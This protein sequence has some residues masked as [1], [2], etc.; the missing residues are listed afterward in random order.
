[1]EWMPIK[2]LAFSMFCASLAPGVQLMAGE[3]DHWESPVQAGDTCRY[4][5]PGGPVDGGWMLRGNADTAWNAGP[6]GVG[7]GDGDD[8]TES[9]TCLSVYCRYRFGLTDPSVITK[10]ILDVDFDDGFVAYLNGVELARNNLGQAGSATSWDQPADGWH[11]ADLYQGLQPMRFVPEPEILDLLVPGENIL[12]IEV[13]NESLSSSDLSSNVFLHAGI[14]TQESYFPAPP[15]WFSPPFTFRETG[16]PL[17]VIDTRGM[18]ILNEPRIT[19]HM[20]LVFHPDGTPGT[21]GG[22]FNGYDGQISI[23]LRGESTLWIYPKKSYSIELQEPDGSNNNVSLLGLPEENDF[24]LYGPYGDKSLIRN[25]LTYTLYEQMGHYAPRTRFIELIVNEEYQGLY[26]LTEKIKRDKNRVDMATLNPEDV[27][28][29]EITGGYLLRVD[30]L[31][32]MEWYEY[33]ESPVNPPV[34]GF[35][36]ITYQYFDPAYEELNEW[37]RLYIRDYM[38][39]F[40]QVLAA[41]GFKDPEEG[42]RAYLDIPSFTDLMILNELSKDVDGYRLSHYFYKQKV[43]GGGKLVSGPPWDYNLTY[44]NS[45]YTSDVHETY[46]WVYNLNASMYWWTRTMQDP[47]FR[48]NVYCRWDSLRAT[49]LAGNQIHGL[50]DSCLSLI[51]EANPRNF[52]RWPI[53]G[54]YVWP[55]SFVG[56]DYEDEENFLR[57]WIDRRLGWIDSRW[58][59]LCIPDAVPEPPVIA[60]P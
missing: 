37:Q 12:A 27:D 56:Q 30:K 50:I 31:S 8:R 59:G 43:T 57:D 16:L 39:E 45:D 9:D 24:T 20:G 28:S 14:A 32:D 29:V 40:E 34:G 15:A 52:S 35:G 36:R 4:L 42:Y 60:R 1:M 23:E 17:M 18:E 48:N 47:W 13:H 21:P 25:V 7:Y 11:E 3:P 44:G 2:H 19:A 49:V 51:G 10:L 54:V 46:N 6:G 5:V 53:L 33:W 26:V 55:N 41:T 38:E 58:A 22:P